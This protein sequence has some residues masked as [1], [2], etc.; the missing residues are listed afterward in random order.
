M[1]R[2]KSLGTFTTAT[3]WPDEFVKKSPKCSQNP[4]FVKTLPWEKIAQNF[5]KFV[6]TCFGQYFGRFFSQQH[7][8]TLA[9]T[10]DFAK[11]MAG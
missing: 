5:V 9:P 1:N 8:V 2:S 10:T 4:F 11:D 6:K 7:P 3:W